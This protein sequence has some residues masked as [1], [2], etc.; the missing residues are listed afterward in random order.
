MNKTFLL[1][2]LVLFF[3]VLAVVSCRRSEMRVVKIDVP[4]MSDERGARIVTNAALNEVVGQYDGIAHAIEIDLS[5]KL[6]L[7]HES[8]RLSSPAYLRH[9]AER[10]REVGF[11]ARIL[12]AGLNPP[13]LVLDDDGLKQIWPNRFTTAIS[14]PDMVNNTDANIIVDAIAYARLGRDDPRI[15]VHH[16]SR[17]LVANYQS[18]H[19]ALKNIEYA[20]ACTGFDANSTPANLG[21]TEAMPQGWTPVR[22]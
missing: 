11:K 13:P 22:L 9:I 15:A 1:S 14:V 6:V 18:L 7:Y 21:R 3:G 2:I 10:I 17:T 16:G 20:I 5:K 8:E 19:L 12:G 4:Q